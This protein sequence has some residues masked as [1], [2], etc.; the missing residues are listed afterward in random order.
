MKNTQF[1]WPREELQY[2]SLFLFLSFILNFIAFYIYSQEYIL[3]CIKPLNLN[4][5]IFTNISEAFQAN[6]SF[7]LYF[8]I[9]LIIPFLIYH[10]YCFF[11]PGY[12]LYERKTSQNKFLFFLILWS[13]SFLFAWKICLPILWQFFAHFQFQTENFQLQLEARILP[14]LEFIFQVFFVSEFIF[15]FPFWIYLLIIKNKISRQIFNQNRNLSYIF[16]FICSAALCPPEL[17]IQ[18]SLSFLCII[19]FEI[20]V[21]M[22]YIRE[23]YMQIFYADLQHEEI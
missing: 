4:H 23:F 11:V 9:F 22:V 17:M 3:E 18:L 15:L 12:F 13:L 20:L 10:I 14:T 2:R 16:L 6:I 7:A 5:L 1:P 21:F 8:G 19:S